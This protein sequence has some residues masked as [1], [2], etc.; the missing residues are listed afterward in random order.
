[1]A[2][3]RAGVRFFPHPHL[4]IMII[5]MKERVMRIQH[6]R[7][8]PGRVT[9]L[10]IEFVDGFAE[11]EELHPERRQALLQHGFTIDETADLEEQTV[12]QLR[13]ELTDLGVEV[14]STW[15]KPRLVKELADYH[16][17]LATAIRNVDQQVVDGWEAAHAR[18]PEA[19]STE[20]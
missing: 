19:G 13:T 18:T 9:D 10:G 11:V 8:Q 15:R 5:N 12:E 2:L 14:K 17:G 3:H 6:P 20:D 4:I 16:E 7:F 1:M